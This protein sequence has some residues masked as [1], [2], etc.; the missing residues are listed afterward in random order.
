MRS[1]RILLSFILF[2]SFCFSKNDGFVVPEKVIESDLRFTNPSKNMIFEYIKQRMLQIQE[3]NFCSQYY[4]SYSRS[5]TNY[6]RCYNNLKDY[7]YSILD[8]DSKKRTSLSKVKSYI[9]NKTTTNYKNLADIRKVSESEISKKAMEFTQAFVYASNISKIDVSQLISLVE[10]ESLYEKSSHHKGGVGLSQFVE[11]GIK[12]NLEQLGIFNDPKLLKT[13]IDNWRSMYKEMY[14]TVS[15]EDIH[16]PS[17]TKLDSIKNKSKS[18]VYSFIKDRLKLSSNFSIFFGALH[19]KVK[20]WNKCGKENDLCDSYALNAR[21]GGNR[22]YILDRYQKTFI[23][24][25]G[26][27]KTAPC[28]ADENKKKMQIRNC[29]P[30]LLN[31]VFVRFEKY[32]KS[33]SVLLETSK[34]FKE[35]SKNMIDKVLFQ[36][37]DIR[38]DSIVR[39]DLRTTLNSLED[40]VKFIEKTCSGNKTNYLSTYIN[41]N[42]TEIMKASYKLSMINCNTLEITDLEIDIHFDLGRG[43]LSLLNVKNYQDLEPQ[44]PECIAESYHT[45]EAKRPSFDFLKSLN[46]SGEKIVKMKIGDFSSNEFTKDGEKRCLDQMEDKIILEYKEIPVKFSNGKFDSLDYKVVYSPYFKKILSITLMK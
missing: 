12:E 24:Y 44:E 7:T 22:W 25:N 19:L 17:L 39:Q 4:W 11:I 40:E 45:G 33:N 31:K 5:K 14:Y 38:E 41:P 9:K 28:E 20:M 1:M 21:E 23:D 15:S 36:N 30:K 8:I 42:F 34:D 16:F 27:T 3:A 29:Y 18:D 13:S 35:I 26:N 43:A 10:H 37:F 2:S 32:V 6:Y 46:I